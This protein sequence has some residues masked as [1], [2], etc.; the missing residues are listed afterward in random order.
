MRSRRSTALLVSALGVTGVT[1]LIVTPAQAAAP[2]PPYAFTSDRDGD[3]EIYLRAPDG[4]VQR[5]TDN[6]V[7][8][9]GAV[10]SPDGEQLAFVRGGTEAGG[11]GIW[12]M[13]ADG[14]DQRQLTD[15]GVSE[16]GV[17][18]F[19]MAPAWS[20][21][22][23]R[24]AF[25]STRDGA[26]PEIYVMDADGSDQVRLTSTAPYVTDHAPTFSP[27]GRYIAFSSSR[28]GDS[29]HEIYRMR[30]DGSD[31]RRLTRTADGID[32]SAPEYSPD[33]SRILF[34]ST[35][36]GAAHDLYT[37]KANGGKVRPLAG[38]PGLVD[39]V[40]GRWTSDGRQVLY[41]TFGSGDPARDSVWIVGADGTDRLRLS[42][43]TTSDYL[44]DPRPAQ[45]R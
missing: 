8:D 7:G 13:D 5:L 20:P 17:P 15:P 28:V 44:P 23:S 3:P 25:A 9:Y 2:V 26:E 22:G 30:A 32:D 39:D 31:V 41:Q 42:D 29:N 24:I 19:D 36:G 40:F 45:G 43:G 21:D 38:E 18:A 14:G 34:S 1:T 37:M 11:D 33:G 6:E 27:D 16:D 35:R 12:V 4:T 10:W